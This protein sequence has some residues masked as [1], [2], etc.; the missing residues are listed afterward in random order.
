[1]LAATRAEHPGAFARDEG[2]L[3]AAAKDYG[4]DGARRAAEEWTERV[5]GTDRAERLRERRFLKL[6]PLPSGMTRLF[7]ELDPEGGRLV[8]CALDGIAD[9]GVRSGGTGRIERSR[10][11]R[12]ADALEDMAARFLASSDR[13]VV[14]S[15]RPHL[16]VTVD[17]HALRQIR[18]G[19]VLGSQALR[20]I[21]CDAMLTRV[22][23]A[24]PAMPL[25]IGRRT[26]IV[27]AHLM[28]ALRIRDGGCTL[29]GCDRPPSWAEAH[30][31]AHWLDQGQTELD[32][33]ALICR[34]HHRA[35]HEDGFQAEMVDGPPVVSATGRGAPGRSP[36]TA[37]P[38]VTGSPQWSD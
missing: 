25:E 5:D 18:G 36:R 30:H 31:V 35:V 7:G 17:V 24:G 34:A 28:K 26:R 14:G 6:T 15:E 21:A 38:A 9:A 16:N 22:V 20:R 2:M 29:R 3:L 33:L 19:D 10:G 4:A 1:V 23:L 8:R 27:P 32:N 13:P 11:Q 12:L 37:G